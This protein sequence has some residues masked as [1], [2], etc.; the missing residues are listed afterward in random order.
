MR[1]ITKI[2]VAGLFI[3]LAMGGTALANADSTGAYNNGGIR[4]HGDFNNNTQG[5]AGCHVTHSA[6]IQKLLK[7]GASGNVTQT[8]FC[9]LCHGAATTGSP[10]DAQDGWV[11]HDTAAS[12]ASDWDAAGTNP[13]YAG[14]FDYTPLDLLSAD[15]MNGAHTAAST[16]THQV[17]SLT[18]TD[19]GFAATIPGGTKSISGG[20]KC[21]SCHDPHKGGVAAR[22]LR[23]T[24]KL[25]GG[26]ETVTVPTMTIDGDSNM[27]TA[28]TNYM[29]EWCAS[30]HSK[31]DAPD[32]SGGTNVAG[33]LG[34]YRHAM[35][36]AVNN[37][38]FATGSNV[39]SS[40][41][42]LAYAPLQGG[43]LMCLT[44]HRV[45][46]ASAV[47]QGQATSWKD[48]VG[49]TKTGTALLRM[50][51]RDVCY[52]CHGAAANNLP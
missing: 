9:Y 14:G 38:T 33:Y 23:N 46:G 25:V 30:C 3:V 8:A 50:S 22:L 27:V 48:D 28:Y 21:A 51:N 5:C 6:S 26:N 17:E 13:S 47:M 10:Y 40:A 34:K 20:L 43:N 35:D 12:S 15:P 18:V 42:Q 24:V 29:S 44:C 19:S 2:V 11:L 37:T 31:F 16:S 45:H 32:N 49:A 39:D 41:E 7:V 4:L 1:L 36:I 52:N